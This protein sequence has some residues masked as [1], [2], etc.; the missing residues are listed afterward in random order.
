MPIEGRNLEFVV[1]IQALYQQELGRAPDP[2]GLA[3]W[4]AHARGDSGEP[5]WNGDR[6]RQALHD[7]P[8][9]VAYRARPPAPPPSVAPHLEVRG[10]DFVNAQ[11]EPTCL[12]AVDQF[13]AFRMFRDGRLAELDAL[14]AESH[15]FGFQFWRVFMMGSKAQNTIFDLFVEPGY[16][17]DV[18]PFAD[19]L[20]AHGI[21][22]LAVIHVDNQDVKAPLGHWSRMADRLRG[23]GTILD[24]GNEWQKNGFDPQSLPDPGMIWSRGSG[25][26]DAVTPQNGATCASFHQ[27]TDWPATLMDAVASEVYMEQHGYTVVMMDEPTRFDED[28]NKSGVSDSVRFAFVLARIY[29]SL[30]DLVCFHSG[31]GQR[32]QLM[33]PNL[34]NVAAAWQ[35]GLAS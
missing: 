8:E 6:I 22:L 13:I 28:S 12:S 10:N 7:S 15:E 4:L 1:T 34:R 29:G 5:P 19:W 16:Y 25:L 24:G 17:D 20:N 33:G 35:R 21:G 27:R 2:D 26:A 31:A 3:G 18:R 9:G 11:G 30:W 14:A 32:G 23:S